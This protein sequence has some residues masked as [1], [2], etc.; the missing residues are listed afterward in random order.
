MPTQQLG[1]ELGRGSSGKVYRALNR[2]SGHF[3]AIKEIPLQGMNQGHLQAVQTEIEL[4]HHLQHPQIVRFYETIRTA[5]NLYLVLEY[6]E[7]GSLANI[8]K[9]FGRFP[10]HI[11]QVYMRQVLQGLEWL[12]SQGVCHRDIKGANLLITKDG[13]VK[14]ADFGV[15]GKL[16]DEAKPNAVVGT[17]YWMAP[18]IIEMSRFTTAS[19]IWSLGCTLI[20]LF[21][22]E[23]PYFEMRPVTALYRIVQDEKPPLPPDLSSRLIDFL[24]CCFVRDPLERATAAQLRVHPW[25]ADKAQKEL[26]PAS[27]RA[28]LVDPAP[29]RLPLPPSSFGRLVVQNIERPGACDTEMCDKT[30]H[31]RPDSDPRGKSRADSAPSVS[32]FSQKLINGNATVGRRSLSASSVGACAEHSECCFSASGEHKANGGSNAKGGNGGDELRR[33]SIRLER[34][35]SQRWDSPGAAGPSS[36][37]HESRGDLLREAISTAHIGEANSNGRSSLVSRTDCTQRPRRPVEPLELL[38]HTP[39]WPRKHRTARESR[40]NIHVREDNVAQGDSVP[41]HRLHSTHGRHQRSPRRLAARGDKFSTIQSCSPLASSGRSKGAMPAEAFVAV[42]SAEISRSMYLSGRSSWGGREAALQRSSGGGRHEDAS[43]FAVGLDEP[44]AGDRMQ[45]KGGRERH[46]CDT[47]YVYT[48]RNDSDGADMASSCSYTLSSEGLAAQRPV[49]RKSRSSSQLKEQD[50][51]LMESQRN[52]K[53]P[54]M[55]S[56]RD[57]LA[58]DHRAFHS[59]EAAAGDG[60]GRSVVADEGDESVRRRCV[61]VRWVA[62]QQLRSESLETTEH[63]EEVCLKLM[64]TAKPPLHTVEG[65][66]H[67]SDLGGPREASRKHSGGGGLVFHS[68]DEAISR[69][70]CGANASRADDLAALAADDGTKDP[71]APDQRTHAEEATWCGASSLRMKPQQAPLSSETQQQPKMRLHVRA[72]SQR[73]DGNLSTHAPSAVCQLGAIQLPRAPERKEHLLT[74]YLWKRGSHWMSFSYKRRLFFLKDDALCFVSAARAAGAGPV[75]DES[76]FSESVE[77]NPETSGMSAG[78]D[79]GALPAGVERRIPLSSIRNVRVHSKVKF[80]FELVS[81][82]RSYRLRAPS[83]QALAVW[84]T[85]ISAEWMQL[86]HREPMKAAPSQPHCSP[87]PCCESRSRDFAEP[88]PGLCLAAG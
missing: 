25:L 9:H 69:T 59:Y 52:P 72:I 49:E 43:D 7:N 34:D 24:N 78:S 27:K 4:L 39:P 48:S 1:E 46:G 54:E 28:L 56:L 73:A 62:G 14:L 21:H 45:C 75:D 51:T 76:L 60:F 67:P 6:V 63:L 31:L 10:E 35:K 41:C 18:E 64:S 82:S 20:E 58:F 26:V 65:H 19:D 61:R 87:S 80:E 88:E 37:C 36:S 79:G 5:E 86:Q 68:I 32:G 15:A 66:A 81:A 8:L 77:S 13:Q 83:A 53:T 16:T 33:R 70:W 84:V 29:A 42:A 40:C 30:L 57:A 38:P 44:H 55:S 11:L 17:P 47:K 71:P 3:V 23:P 22:G 2:E 50:G 74:G 85:T 12:H